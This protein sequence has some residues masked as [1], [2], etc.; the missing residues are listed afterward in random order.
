MQSPA[1][2]VHACVLPA[3][4]PVPVGDGGGDPHL[5]ERGVEVAAEA[6]DRLR[7]PFRR[8]FAIAGS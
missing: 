2:S 4:D 1:S 6:G 7:E 3:D 8:G 5:A